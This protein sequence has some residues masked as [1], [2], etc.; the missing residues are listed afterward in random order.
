MHEDIE[1]AASRCISLEHSLSMLQT[2]S[3]ALLTLDAALAMDTLLALVKRIESLHRVTERQKTSALVPYRNHN[4][5]LRAMQVRAPLVNVCKS[6]SRVVFAHFQSL[7]EK[8]KN[9]TKRYTEVSH[10]L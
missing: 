10:Y 5:A 4:L 3:E 6:Q 1:D 8:A 7:S 9:L 2:E